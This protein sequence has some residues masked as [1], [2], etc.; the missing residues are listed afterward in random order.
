MSKKLQIL[1]VMFV[2]DFDVWKT[3]DRYIAISSDP[4]SE[5]YLAFMQKTRYTK[6]WDDK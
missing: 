2:T 5:F 3:S 6:A 1:T 4:P